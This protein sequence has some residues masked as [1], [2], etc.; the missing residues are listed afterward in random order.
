MKHHLYIVILSIGSSSLYFRHSFR[1]CTFDPLYPL[2]ITLILLPS[3]NYLTV[4]CDYEFVF[5]LSFVILISL[6]RSPVYG[7]C[8]L[9][10]W[11]LISSQQEFSSASKQIDQ[12]RRSINS[13]GKRPLQQFVLQA[14]YPGFS[15]VS[16]TSQLHGQ[17]SPLSLSIIKYKVAGNWSRWMISEFLKNVPILHSLPY[18]LFRCKNVANFFQHLLRLMLR[19]NAS[20]ASY[21]C[22]SQCE[23][24]ALY[25]YCSPFPLRERQAQEEHRP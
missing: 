12:S 20:H 15:P 21:V 23:K 10:S 13:V 25:Y 6:K 11:N 16:T 2:L 5:V 1:H 3:S 4:I 17:G 24:M 14:K 18:I 22:I 9:S 7:N 19:K 8:L